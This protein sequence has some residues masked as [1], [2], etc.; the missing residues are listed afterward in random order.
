MYTYVP[1]QDVWSSSA[2]KM[3]PAP[4]LVQ[5]NTSTRLPPLAK[6]A[7]HRALCASSSTPHAEILCQRFCS[8]CCSRLELNTFACDAL[9]IVHNKWLRKLES[10]PQRTSILYRF[11]LSTVFSPLPNDPSRSRSSLPGG[12]ASRFHPHRTPLSV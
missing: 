7:R 5:R 2:H 8:R 4:T 3:C 6:Y 1:M 10:S 9:I 12:E 11:L